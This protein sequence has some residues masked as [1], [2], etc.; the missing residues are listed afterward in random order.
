[1]LTDSDLILHERP[2]FVTSARVLNN[3]SVRA[4]SVRCAVSHSAGARLAGVVLLPLLHSNAGLLDQST[5]GSFET[6]WR[7]LLQRLLL[8]KTSGQVF[9]LYGQGQ[10]LH[11][12]S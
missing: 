7:M 3:V 6:L 10:M 5:Q 4:A 1:M 2:V 12:K 9:P 8:V 11:R